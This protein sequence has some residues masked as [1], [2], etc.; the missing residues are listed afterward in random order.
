M[1]LIKGSQVVQLLSYGQP[2]A[3]RSSEQSAVTV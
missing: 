2:W 1:M 3:K